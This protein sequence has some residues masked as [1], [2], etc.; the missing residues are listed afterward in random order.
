[1][2]P[3][4]EAGDLDGR[5]TGLMA[6]AHKQFPGMFERMLPTAVDARRKNR[7]LGVKPAHGQTH[8]EVGGI[9]VTP[10]MNRAVGVLAAK[11]TKGIYYREAGQIFPGHGCLMVNWFSNEQIVRSGKYPVFE[12][13]Q[14][15]GGIV[16]AVQRSGKYLHDQFQYKLNLSNDRELVVVQAQFGRAFGMVVV[17]STNPGQLE[18]L[19]ARMR[20]R[21]GRD[22]P[23]EILQTNAAA[24]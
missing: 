7:V 8:Q 5:Q 21:F 10:E 2:D 9:N 20:E 11:L 18:A 1:M 4:E 15:L 3:F 19:V 6:M 16:P 13:L 17:G 23:F 22:G 14:Q 24:Q 12:L